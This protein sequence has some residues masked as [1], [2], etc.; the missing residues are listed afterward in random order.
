[1]VDSTTVE[2][3][4]GELLQRVAQRDPTA[5]GLLYD[6]LAG[7]LFATALQMLADRREAEEVVQDVFLQIWAK[8]GQFDHAIGT[9][10]H[11]TLGITRNRCIDYLRSRQRRS[12]LLEQLTHGTAVELPLAPSGADRAGLSQ[13]ELAAVR[14]AVD[15][16]PADQRQAISLAFYGGLTHSEIADALHEPLGTVKARI[17]RGMLKLRDSLGAY[18]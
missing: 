5:L 13:D 7:V 18:V 4:Q 12:R 3:S 8:A 17:R 11:W 2:Q 16:L 15:E 1:M 6:Q 14:R 9:P 10:L